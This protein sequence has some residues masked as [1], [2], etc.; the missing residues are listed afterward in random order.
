MRIMWRTLFTTVAL[1]FMLCLAGLVMSGNSRYYDLGIF[2]YPSNKK[3][4][5][6]TSC[7]ST[8]ANQGHSNNF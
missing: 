8:G 5:G 6:E 2:C 3:Y 4:H 1:V 7:F